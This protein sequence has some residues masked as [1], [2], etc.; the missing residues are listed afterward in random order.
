MILRWPTPNIY[1]IYELLE[2]MKGLVLQTQSYRISMTQGNN[3]KSER[4]PSIDSVEKPGASNPI[5]DSFK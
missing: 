2:H 5:N 4:S 1:P 3:R